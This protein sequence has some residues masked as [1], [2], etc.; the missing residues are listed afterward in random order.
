MIRSWFFRPSR[1]PIPPMPD[2]QVSAAELTTLSRSKNLSLRLAVSRH[3]NTD[4]QTLLELANDPACHS[5]LIRR[6]DLTV[7]V[8]QILIT[9]KDATV[10]T[11]AWEILD[12][13]LDHQ[14]FSID[15]FFGEAQKEHLEKLNDQANLSLVYQSA[16]SIDLRTLFTEQALQY[17]Y[18]HVLQAPNDPIEG[19][20]ST[21]PF[22]LAIVLF[23]QCLH[24]EFTAPSDQSILKWTASQQ[25]KIT[26][27]DV[28]VIHLM[29]QA[30]FQRV[31]DLNQELLGKEDRLKKLTT[32]AESIQIPK[33][34][35]RLFQR[36]RP[37]LQPEHPEI[38]LLEREIP[39]VK[40]RMQN[41]HDFSR[42]FLGFSPLTQLLHPE[43]IQPHL[44]EQSGNRFGLEAIVGH[45]L[46]QGLQ[47]QIAVHL[48]ASFWNPATRDAVCHLLYSVCTIP[49]PSGRSNGYALGFVV[50]CLGRFDQKALAIASPSTF[51]SLHKCLSL[52][53]EAYKQAVTRHD[54][55]S[56][57]IQYFF[58]LHI[59]YENC[60]NQLYSY[61]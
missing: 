55:K 47:D 60:L 19:E 48:S 4:L 50:R 39:Q 28:I 57:D 35:R 16:A 36:S 21:I 8:L 33:G 42:V 15:N 43:C 23:H 13:W 54:R 12:L 26:L 34:K 1:D 46:P 20:L 61:L 29:Q 24:P 41:Y 44:N 59:Q 25:S 22:A 40:G 52:V 51:D 9:S 6:A 18:N 2:S 58:E 32:Q 7:P 17:Q 37:K 3:P 10:Q 31:E 11:R 49:G 53:H 45:R 38:M 27:A 5:T 56:D 30:I 14:R